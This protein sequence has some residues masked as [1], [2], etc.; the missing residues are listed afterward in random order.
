M[1]ITLAPQVT[2]KQVGKEAILL[3]RTG[4]AIYELDEVGA[5]LWQL[6]ANDGDFDTALAQ[7]LA[8]FEPEAVGDDDAEEEVR[9][10]LLEL[11]DD[12]AQAGLV[13]WG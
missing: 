9:R 10:E 11:L 5:R 13:A 8:E 1:E 6:L 7:L 3:N 2:L 4:E 12:M